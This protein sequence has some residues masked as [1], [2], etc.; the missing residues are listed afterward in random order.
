MKAEER[1]LLIDFDGVLRHFPRQCELAPGVPEAALRAAALA[2]EHIGAAITGR[3]SDEQWRAQ[4]IERL[5]E[6][7]PRALAMAAVRRWSAQVGELDQAALALVQQVRSWAKVVLVTNATTRLSADLARL[8]LEQAFDAVVNSSEV[9]S[10]KPNARIFQ[11]ALERA[12]V[13]RARS[14]FVDD[15]RGHVEAARALAIPALHFSGVDALR[16][17]IEQQLRPD[18]P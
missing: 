6:R 16:T 2:P 9:G 18:G 15:M 14:L 7:F 11:V 10:A 1:A 13:D 4:V 12:G 8:G 17:A 3:V 5:A